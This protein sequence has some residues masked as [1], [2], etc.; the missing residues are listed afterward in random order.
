MK[1][2]TETKCI[3]CGILRSDSFDS[4][5]WG[6][7]KKGGGINGHHVFRPTPPETSSWEE[8]F[9]AHLFYI[10]KKYNLHAAMLKNEVH[11]TLAIDGQ[12]SDDMLKFVKKLA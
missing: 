12:V 11:S 6:C 1:K 2:D 7:H 9:Y 8:E 4:P 10:L 3:H 5:A